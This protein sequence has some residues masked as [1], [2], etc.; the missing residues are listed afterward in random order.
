[1]IETSP[2]LKKGQYQVHKNCRV[3]GSDKLTKYLDLGYLPLSNNLATSTINSF[4]KERFPLQVLFCEE[5][6]LSQLSIVVDPE[7]MFGHYVYRSSISKTYTNH[8][9]QMARE[10]KQN[11]TPES[12]MIDIGSNDGTLLKEF[13][14]EIGLKIM[15]IDPAE[16]LAAIC[17]AAG[18]PNLTYFWS[19]STARRIVN[20]FGKAD[21]VTA[22]NVFAHCDN[23]KEFIEAAKYVLKED[24][25]LVLEFPYLIDF[26]ENNEFDTIYFEHVSY[27]S[28]KPLVRLCYECEMNVMSVSKQDIHGGTVRVT[29]GQGEPDNSV[30]HFL[31]SEAGYGQVGIYE[32]WT[33]KVSHT[34]NE[35]KY[36]LSKLKWEGKKIAAFAAS[37]KGNTLL[38]CANITVGTISYIVDQTPEKIGKYS[39]GTGIPIVSMDDLIR[40][41]PDYLL[42]LSWNFKTEIIEKCK[43]AGFKGK[44]IIPIPEFEVID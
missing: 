13:K 31:E 23:V 8:C 5:C 29:I 30:R 20:L 9:R 42:I 37:A 41:P 32:E 34:V 6:G 33:T 19:L 44:Y 27:F 3:C 25:K 18:I 7:V 28:L 38:N 24:G 36:H 12:F 26:I 4:N 40:T 2:S 14:D 39:P 15:G 35:L 16:N 22:T 17:D 21:L 43:A 11:L 1:M 10:L